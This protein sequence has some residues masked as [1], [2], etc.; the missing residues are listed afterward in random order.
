MYLPSIGGCSGAWE[1]LARWSFS[2]CAGA[3]ALSPFLVALC[4]RYFHMLTREVATAAIVISCGHIHR[5]R[6][7]TFR[8]R[9]L[10]APAIALVC[11]APRFGSTL[12][13]LTIRS[14]GP[15]RRSAVLS[16]GGQQRPLNSSVRHHYGKDLSTHQSLGASLSI[17]HGLPALITVSL[18]SR[19][20]SHCPLAVFSLRCGWRIHPGLKAFPLRLRQLGIVR[21]PWSSGVGSRRVSLWL[22]LTSSWLAGGTRHLC[23]RPLVVVVVPNYSFKRTAAKGRATIM[24]CAAAAA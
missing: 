18:S 21:P 22:R 7:P 19:V 20:G 16:C 9:V 24:R 8:A 13:G 1:L 3:V 12:C 11:R 5:W 10:I 4:M 23:R 2:A 15:L 17:C 14:S 6:R